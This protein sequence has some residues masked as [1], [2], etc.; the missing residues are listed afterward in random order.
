M[1]W[2]IPDISDATID[3]LRFPIRKAG[4]LTE[5]AVLAGLVFSALQGTFDPRR[6]VWQPRWVCLTLGICAGYAM[7]DEWHQSWE[8]TRQ[9]SPVDVGIDVTGATLGLV[10]LWWL[11]R[12]W[13]ARRRRRSGDGPE[14]D[15]AVGG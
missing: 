8:P 6:W 14:V 12:W 5:Y 10:C 2:L 3:L 9:A 7:S 11:G 13:A 4:H 1:R 15:A